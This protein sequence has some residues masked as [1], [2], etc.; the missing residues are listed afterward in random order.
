MHIHTY[1]HTHNTHNIN[2]G[3]DGGC[4]T[5][6]RCTL[7]CAHSTNDNHPRLNANGRGCIRSGNSRMTLEHTI[8]HRHGVPSPV[9]ADPPTLDWQTCGSMVVKFPPASP[10][11][12]FKSDPL[13]VY[14]SKPLWTPLVAKFKEEGNMG[15]E[16]TQ[17]NRD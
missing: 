10:N 4:M 7:E 17:P 3:N 11:H 15:Y 5:S 2:N 12:T 9:M 6:T 1:I 16:Q 14:V 13:I 8:G